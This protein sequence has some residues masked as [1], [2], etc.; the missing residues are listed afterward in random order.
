MVV[1]HYAHVP[2][3]CAFTGRSK[4][5]CALGLVYERDSRGNAIRRC[6]G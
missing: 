3:T 5:D 1:V 6:V 4:D 2:A